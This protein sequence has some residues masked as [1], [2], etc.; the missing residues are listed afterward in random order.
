MQWHTYLNS[1]PH[2]L[3]EVPKTDKEA[4]DALIECLEDWLKDDKNFEERSK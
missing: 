2:F 3:V 1:D 4:L